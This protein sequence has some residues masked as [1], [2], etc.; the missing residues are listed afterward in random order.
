MKK[1]PWLSLALLLTAYTTF[2]WFFTHT[3]AQFL[4][5]SAATLLAWGLILSFTLLQALLLTTLFDGLRL[6]FGR[7]L[8]SDVGY[9]TLIIVL[10]LS[11][12][13]ALIGLRVT[14][15]VV[16][17]VAAEV[18]ARLDLQDARFSRLQAF[19]VLSIISLAGLA[20]GL[21]ATLL[22]TPDFAVVP[23]AIGS[24]GTALPE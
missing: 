20:I 1:F 6:M 22:L 7:W 24:P 2:S 21:M 15:Y 17:L 9:F 18:L 13:I 10:S 4:T 23:E 5:F 19:T 16:V 11:V 8:R 3:F 14:G 12:T